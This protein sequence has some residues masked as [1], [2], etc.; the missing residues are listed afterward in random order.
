MGI[1]LSSELDGGRPGWEKGWEVEGGGP[2]V[3]REGQERIEII[4][5]KGGWH[6]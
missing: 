4:R 5:G 1:K 3:G 2:E 6:L